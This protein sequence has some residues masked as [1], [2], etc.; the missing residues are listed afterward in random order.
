MEALSAIRVTDLSMDGGDNAI[1]IKSNWSGGG[2][3]HDVVY[4][5][6]A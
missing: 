3:V 2:L 4:E 1:R 6:N 5:D